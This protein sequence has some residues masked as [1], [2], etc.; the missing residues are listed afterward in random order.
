MTQGRAPRGELSRRFAWFAT[1][2]SA[3]HSPLYSRLAA[4]IAGD[5]ELL[6]LAQRATSG[7]EPNLFLSA[8]H[9]LLLGGAGHPVA[10]FYPNLAEG[11]PEGG[12]PY[13]T[14]RS[15]CVEHREEIEEIISTRRVQTNEVRRCALLLPAF[16][17][18]AERTG[19]PLSLVEVGASAGLNLLFDCYA[20]DYGEG[21]RRG[22][23]GSPV[24]I[25]CNV[26][27]NHEVPLPGHLPAVASRIGMDLNPL[28]VRDPASALWLRALIWPEEYAHRVPLLEAA[29][30]VAR[31]EPPRLLRGDALD[32]LPEVLNNIPTGTIACVFHTFTI[33]QF[34]EEARERF[35]DLLRDHAT[36]RGLYRVSVEWIGANAPLLRLAFYEDNAEK[37]TLLARCDD[38]GEW[39]EWTDPGD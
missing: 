14:F 4:G 27:G 2:L 20:Y 26:R 36:R 22:D 35:D 6:T 32:L 33:N 12:D 1:E 8:V 30:S 25:C 39:L 9:S 31:D 23:P 19:K 7:P 10:R 28:D 38:H 29:I 13:P 3:H 16:G 21:N 15:F 5:S 34:S 18:V 37:V 17:L 11:T 24:R